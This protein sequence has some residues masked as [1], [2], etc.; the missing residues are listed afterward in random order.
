M[1]VPVRDDAVAGCDEEVFL[2]L[3]ANDCEEKFPIFM[4]RKLDENVVPTLQS[5][6]MLYRT[7]KKTLPLAHVDAASQGKH[8]SGVSILVSGDRQT[9]S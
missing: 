9:I 5:R 8:S 7:D 6:P 1:V 4:F 3:A 2:F